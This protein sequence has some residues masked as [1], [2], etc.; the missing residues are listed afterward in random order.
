MMNNMGRLIHPAKLGLSHAPDMCGA[1]IL[2]PGDL[3]DLFLQVTPGAPNVDH[4]GVQGIMS[5]DLGETMQRHALG[6]AVAEPVSQVMWADI[7]EAGRYCILLD[8][9]S[10]CPFGKSLTCLTRGEQVLSLLR[11][12]REVVGQ[13]GSRC[14][15][16]GYFPVLV[17]LA[18]YLKGAGA[19]AFLHVVHFE[20]A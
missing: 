8:E 14:G 20:S 11:K 6:H 9:M 10:K 18:D 2:S 12:R 19:L 13:G 3:L 5:H 7:S 1:H 16:E 17:A 4:G 15:V